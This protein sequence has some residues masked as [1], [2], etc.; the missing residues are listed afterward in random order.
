MKRVNLLVICMIL[1]V[2]LLACSNTPVDSDNMVDNDN[3][4]DSD[5]I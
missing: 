3:I 2:I 4:A 5:N 1:S